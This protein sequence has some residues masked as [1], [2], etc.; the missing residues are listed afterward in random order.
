MKKNDFIGREKELELLHKAYNE[1]SKG[2]GKLVL[3]EGDEGSG[4]SSLV[5]TFLSKI[6]NKKDHTVAASECNDK[7]NLNPYAPFKELLIQLNAGG[8]ANKKDDKINKLKEFISEAGTSWIGL[9]PIVGN[10]ASTGISTYQA[11]KKTY[12]ESETTNIEG[13]QDIYRIFENEFRRLAKDKTV[14]I[15]ID[16]LQWADASS[17]NLIFALGKVIRSNPFKVLLIGSF[18]PNEIKAGRNKIS[19][20]GNVVNMRHPFS[21]KLNELRNYCKQENHI[22]KNSNWLIEILVKPFTSKE[23]RILINHKFPNNNFDDEF[24]N[25]IEN[26]TD[27]QPLYVVEIL[28]YLVR[29]GIISTNENSFISDKI[30]INELPVSLN[31]VISEK[32]ERLNKDLKKVLSYASVNGE[33]FSVQV[34]EKILKIDELDLLDYLQE[35]RQKHDLLEAEEPKRVKHLFMELYSFTQTL[36]QKYLYENMDNARRRALHRHVASTIKEL[37]GEEF[38]ENNK[39]L[40][41]KYNL[42]IQIGQGLIDGV[43]LSL[44]TNENSENNEKQPDPNEFLNASKTEI[45]NAENSYEQYAMDECFDFVNKS[46]AFLSKIEDSNKEKLILKFD[47]NL[48][49]CKAL[50]WQGHYQESFDTSKTLIELS[51]NISDEKYAAEANL[52]SGMAKSKLGYGKEAISFFNNAT[53]YYET[54]DNYS[55]LWKSYYEAANTKIDIADYNKAF[56]LLEKALLLSEKISDKSIKGRTLLSLGACSSYK[57]LEDAIVMNYFNE[58]LEIFENC[59]N[60]YYIGKTF[61]KIGLENNA[62]GNHDLAEEFLNK[63][64]T[65]AQEQNDTVN[66]SNYNNNLAL[67]YSNKKEHDKAIEFYKKTLLIDEMLDDKPMIAKSKRNIATAYA[68]KGEYHTAIDYF[69][70]ALDTIKAINNPAELA[71]SYFNMARAYEL[72]QDKEKTIDYYLKS[73]HIRS[74]IDDRAG[75]SGD[76]YLLGNFYY[77]NKDYEKASN[78]LSKSLDFL[79]EIGNKTFISAANDLLGSIEKAKGNNKIAIDYFNAALID[80]KELNQLYN[81]ADVED[82]LG[83]VY[84]DLDDYEKSIAHYK[85]ALISAE[86]NNDKSQL[87]Y[88]YKNIAGE[89]FNNKN[90]ENSIGYYKEAIS[91]NTELN[92]ENELAHNYKYLG[93]S[94]YYSQQ[95]KLAIETFLKELEFQLNIQEDHSVANCYFNL[96][97]ANYFD[98]QNEKAL[99]Y[100]QKALSYFK[101]LDDKL[102]LSYTYRNIGN[103]YQYLDNNNILVIDNYEKAIAIAENIEDKEFLGSL[104]S[105]IGNFYYFLKDYKNSLEFYKKAKEIDKDLNLKVPLANDYKYIGFNYYFTDNNELAI[106]NFKK[107]LQLELELNDFENLC[108][109]YSNLGQAYYWNNKYTDSIES[110]KTTIEYKIKLE[111]ESSEGVA[112]T[113]LNLARSYNFNKQYE[114]AINYQLKGLEIK[115]S[116]H[117]EN[118]PQTDVINFNLAKTYFYANLEDLAKKALEISFQYRKEQYGNDSEELNEV[119]EFY[120]KNFIKQNEPAVQGQSA[121]TQTTFDPAKESDIKQEFTL[122]I[123]YGDENYDNQL[124]EDALNNYLNSL[125]SINK[126]PEGELKKEQLAIIHYKLGMTYNNIKNYKVARGSLITSTNGFIEVY[127]RNHEDTARS[128]SYLGDTYYYL[129]DYENAINCHSEALTGYSSVNNSV[130]SAWSHHD[131]GEDY[132]WAEDY[133]KSILHFKHCLDLRIQL[134]GNEHNEVAT[135]YFKLGRSYYWNEEYQLSILNQTKAYEMRKKLCGENSPE[136]DD[137]RFELGK[138]YYFANMIEIS[139]DYLFQTLNFRKEYYGEDTSKYDAVKN[140]IEK[141][142]NS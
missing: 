79:S 46:L 2:L 18:R 49:K 92:K 51:N 40:K 59:K 70:E 42:H 107:Q 100:Y 99:E 105:V 15:F 7:E 88:I 26:L 116:I 28:D 8:L 11:Y 85:E 66:I 23:I 69:N 3:I 19:E 76:Y 45:Q 62:K 33:E 126:L 96:G 130:M 67:I 119:L 91:V 93:L 16:D 80:F 140:W 134:N 13:E 31:G 95:Y 1:A 128:F 94:Y 125:E 17:L 65:I 122:S 98:D 5:R 29:N 113:Y 108:D 104:Y 123:G 64:L 44:V 60:N 72:M 22:I 43:N 112:D 24:F 121:P 87:S 55:S 86:R 141:H 61:S 74:S 114:E 73:I 120:N 27:G 118:S 84:S 129:D 9:I 37:Y 127:G 90:Y 89:H 139:K 21:D 35:L 63:A 133:E 57:W 101:K 83:T 50:L 137:S 115:K 117:G 132:Y 102:N 68:D 36:V 47:T 52:A 71:S 82:S 10:F 142:I 12:S 77:Q 53:N 25:S 136:V 138:E 124:Y 103:C 78:Y 106:D 110:F 20:T 38:I 131:L 81:I 6:L 41:D 32:V 48:I 97:L 75:L 54:T 39:A 4:K 111:G 14:V 135:A 34:I 56:N 30:K 58:A 109:C